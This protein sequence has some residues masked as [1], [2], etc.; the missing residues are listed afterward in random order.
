MANPILTRIQNIFFPTVRDV[1]PQNSERDLRNYISPVQLQRLRHDVAMWRDCTQESELAYFPQRVKMQRMFI[2]TIFNGHTYACI[3]R[4]KQLTLLREWEFKNEAGEVSENNEKIFDKK[5][6]ADLLEYILDARFFGYSLVALGD[7]VDGGFP[8]LSI[9]RRA[10]VSPDRLNVTHLI[11]ALSGAEFMDE[12]YVDW[13]VWIPTVSENGISKCGY[14]LLYNVALYEIICRNLLG[15]NAD[16]AELYG[17]PVRVGTTS[18]TDEIERAEYANALA[19]MA[20]SGWILKDT[21][22]EL[23]LLESKGNGQGFKIYADLEQR[24]EKKISKIILGHA[25]ALDSTAGKLGGGQGEDSP[26]AQALRDIR[27]EDASFVENIVNTILIPKLIK[28]GLKIDTSY[29][30]CFTNNE[31][32]EWEEKE[33]LENN[34]KISDIAL[35]MKNAGLQMDAKYFDDVTGIPT[36]PVTVA[37]SMP[38]TNR[39][40][41]KLE[42]LYK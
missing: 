18:K 17:M 26:V 23:D 21:L 28:L 36:T 24:C 33:Q 1:T 7:L 39:I 19:N 37:P 8:D 32:K 4:R 9:I 31:D 15:A 38:F 14:G 12:P 34:K 29:S 40:K 27:A 13:H 10:N 20:S 11:Y 16:A 42:T 35:T 41:N 22:D 2:D 25:D 3:K 30:F 6:F 5:W